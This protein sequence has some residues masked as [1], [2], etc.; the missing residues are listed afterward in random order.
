MARLQDHLAS[1]GNKKVSRG[2]KNEYDNRSSKSILEKELIA[3]EYS[4]KKEFQYRFVK[5]DSFLV[6]WDVVLWTLM[7]LGL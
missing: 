7:E 2:I 4:D 5:L 6:P 3:L 1:V